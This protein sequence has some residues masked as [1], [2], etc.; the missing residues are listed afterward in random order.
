MSGAKRKDM[1]QKV[2]IPSL[3]EGVSKR[4]TVGAVVG[5]CLVS[6]PSLREGVSKLIKRFFSEE[7]KIEFQFPRYGKVYLNITPEFTEGDFENRFNSLAT[8]R[9][10]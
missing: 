1:S 3:R 4:N 9:C 5:G 10:I 7:V 6:I 8:G 2:S